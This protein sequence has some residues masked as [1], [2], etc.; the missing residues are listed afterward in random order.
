MSLAKKADGLHPGDALANLG[1]ANELQPNN[2]TMLYH[3]GAVHHALG[4]KASADRNLKKA[5]S[6]SQNFREADEAR[7][8]LGQ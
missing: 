2:P 4:D 5:L 7:K 1:K 3:I 6:I 8:L